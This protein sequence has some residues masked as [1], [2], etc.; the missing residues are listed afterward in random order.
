MRLSHT[1]GSRRHSICA[2]QYESL[3]TAES[4]RAALS[5]N[6]TLGK[7]TKTI[8]I[9]KRQ[10]SEADESKEQQFN[11]FLAGTVNQAIDYSIGYQVYQSIFFID[12]GSR[13]FGAF[14][15]HVEAI[16]FLALGQHARFPQRQRGQPWWTLRSL[17]APEGDL[18]DH[19]HGSD[20]RRF[21]CRLQ[22]QLTPAQQTR[23]KA[24]LTSRIHAIA[25]QHR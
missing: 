19:T 4:P 6:N 11:G 22:A 2:L 10:N 18:H 21:A 3:G 16:A 25:G 8:Q 9:Q 5:S 14:D 1:H 12:T 23:L 15:T 24:T 20:T 17:Y 7:S 13:A